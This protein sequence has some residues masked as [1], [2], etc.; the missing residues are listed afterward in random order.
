MEIEPLLKALLGGVGSVVAKKIAEALGNG[1]NIDALKDKNDQ[2]IKALE[3]ISK[4]VDNL[5]DTISDSIRM[6]QI[7]AARD[8]VYNTLDKI[9]DSLANNDQHAY[10]KAVESIDA[11]EGILAKLKNMNRALVE[12]Q[13][14]S[15]AAILKNM[16][17]KNWAKLQDPKQYDYGVREFDADYDSNI[18]FLTTVEGLGLSLL[19]IYNNSRKDRTPAQ[20]E[21]ANRQASQ[22][23]DKRVQGWRDMFAVNKTQSSTAYKLLSG[24]IKRQTR[25]SG[26]NSSE[27]MIRSLV[28]KGNGKSKWGE[29]R[30]GEVTLDGCLLNKA[31]MD[32]SQ[33][34]DFTECWVPLR[35]S[36]PRVEW[37]FLFN[38]STGRW[39]ML[40]AMFPKWIPSIDCKLIPLPDDE[41][42]PGRH[43]VFVSIKESR[44][45]YDL[46]PE[47]QRFAG[48]KI[49]FR[50][51]SPAVEPSTDMRDWLEPWAKSSARWFVARIENHSDYL[52]IPQ[53]ANRVTSN[54]I[55]HG[56]DNVERTCNR[57]SL[58]G[59]DIIYDAPLLPN[60]T[61]YVGGRS[62][63]F[64]TGATALFDFAIWKCTG[65]SSKN[66][67]EANEARFHKCKT[68][69]DE[70][71]S[72]G[73]QLGMQREQATWIGTLVLMVSMSY[74]GGDKKGAMYATEFWPL[75]TYK[76]ADTEDM[77]GGYR[78]T[79][80]TSR[81]LQSVR[82]DFDME[83]AVGMV[84][85]G[86][87]AT[88]FKI[89]N[90]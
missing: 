61:T 88:Y 47:W 38:A 58:H 77:T 53:T 43:I 59:E 5:A 37:K 19:L 86:Q 87:P 10:T 67:K 56:T 64:L 4:K 27:P 11:D 29:N 85:L 90:Q 23:S 72:Y 14:A 60:A 48:G 45:F 26:T 41:G 78:C 16:A 65:I 69:G 32:K 81:T 40:N 89:W 15:G 39:T 46:R 7:T 25:T 62:T 51:L 33:L 55:L 66:G 74:G 57:D 24:E 80:F 63:G 30:D 8:R 71:S 76:L 82:V 44:A 20:K 73:A 42:K 50:Q 35:R 1:L 12:Q 79:S 28:K 13:G 83:Q 18:S 9:R 84:S 3:N 31:G 21:T 68:Y 52:L 36:N 70:S 6:T 49:E 54:H 75:E 2:I 22:E 17:D 34:L